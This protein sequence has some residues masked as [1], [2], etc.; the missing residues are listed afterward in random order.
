MARYSSVV[1]WRGGYGVTI[2]TVPWD[3]SVLEMGLWG[4]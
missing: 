4:G 1:A 2:S 3:D